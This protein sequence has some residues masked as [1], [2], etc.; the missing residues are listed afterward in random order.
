MS[1]EKKQTLISL[2]LAGAI[3]Y[4]LYNK[5]MRA[6][7]YM[8]NRDGRESADERTEKELSWRP[9][10]DAEPVVE[11]PAFIVPAITPFEDSA[12]EDIVEEIKETE[13]METVVEI[14]DEPLVE[15]IVVDE[16][17]PD[18]IVEPTIEPVVELEVEEGVDCPRCGA[19]N[20]AEA[21]FCESCGSAMVE[22]APIVEEELVVEEEPVVETI[23][24]VVPDP[25]VEPV[26]EPVA[27]IEPTAIPPVELNDGD[28]EPEV[29]AL[30]DAVKIDPPKP[31]ENVVPLHAVDQKDESAKEEFKSIMDFFSNL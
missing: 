18:P 17:T 22:K 28:E 9:E 2:S 26:I 27:D 16:I 19:K 29:E 11:E 6:G 23:E 13:T 4:Y 30:F 8:L 1:K 5:L 25:I 15:P 3:G 14:Y 7:N 24:E 21:K 12:T 10:V 20:A 31:M